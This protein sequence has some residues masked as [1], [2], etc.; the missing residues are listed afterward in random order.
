VIVTNLLKLFISFQAL[1]PLLDYEKPSD[2]VEVSEA[3]DTTVTVESKTYKEDFLVY[4]Q[5]KVKSEEV[6]RKIND[7]FMKHIE[8]SYKGYLQLKAEMEK[9]KEEEKEH[10]KEFPYS[11]EY[12]YITR[13]DVKFNQDGKLSIVMYDATYSGGA[14]G[15]EGLQTYNFNAKTGERIS[16]KDIVSSE[17][18][19]ASITEYAKNYMRQHQ[20]I[21]FEEK[22]W[23]DFAVNDQ[24]QFYFT[25][26]GIDLIFQQYDVAPY[27]AGHPTI[28]IPSSE[29]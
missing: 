22:M 24:T 16:L 18:K 13:Y 28:S 29:L 12:S 9:F 23:E 4:P 3:V 26:G 27:A 14:H 5:V 19:F 1:F 20:D 25:E 17:S 15:L 7:V 2:M 10:C 8:S 11:C 6:Q 21:F